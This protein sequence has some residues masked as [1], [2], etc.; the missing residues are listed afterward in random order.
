[1]L[2]WP[3]IAIVAILSIALLQWMTQPGNGIP[4]P[5]F[6]MEQP[7]FGPTSY[8][9]LLR[10][11]KNR[12]DQSQ[13]RIV[14]APNE[15]LRHAGAGA[16]ALS[17]FR[18]TGDIAYLDIAQTRI[19]AVRDLAPHP[20]GVPELRAELALARHDLA[21]AARELE[22]FARSSVAPEKSALSEAT[23][24]RGDLALYTGNHGKAEKLYRK[25]AQFDPHISVTLRQ[26]NLKRV[27]GQFDAAI[28]T[29]AGA[30]RAERH[31]PV[32][33]SGIALQTGVIASARGDYAAAADWYDQAETLFSGHWL[34]ALY[35]AE[36]DLANGRTN[37]ALTDLERLARDHG[38]PEAMDMLALV[39]RVRG[40]NAR[41][42]YWAMQA[43]AIWREWS[44]K[45]PAAF[46]AH[47]A[48]HE[49]VFGDAGEALR[50]ARINAKARPY[51]EARLLLARALM[52]NDQASAALT[53]ITL[54][55]Q[56]GWRS[57]Q[58]YANKAQALTIL[59]DS[60]A[61]ETADE[62]A[63]AINPK[64]NDPA[65]RLIWLAHG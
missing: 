58:L 8:A 21:V 27:S 22:I 36:A 49:L 54:A 55:E 33:L 35:R 46:A 6:A 30:T 44:G 43:G 62:Q 15:W 34:T 23:A 13:A 56:S 11:S 12:L 9:D 48:E 18:L 31:S 51:G 50:L 60:D 25:A 61:A 41:S 65:T 29:L 14:R 20:S 17:L 24:M 52:A 7:T 4:A 45:Y 5:V 1:M 10:N 39:W 26:A 37:S 19:T 2:R 32:V 59:G 63:R 40:D 64:I 42:R 53:E 16:A 47:A 57:A 28:A 3:V 38:R